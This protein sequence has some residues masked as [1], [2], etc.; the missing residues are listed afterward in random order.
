MR[1]AK[2]AKGNTDYVNSSCPEA[3]SEPL[4][5]QITRLHGRVELRYLQA[6]SLFRMTWGLLV[7]MLCK[8]FV[9]LLCRISVLPFVILC[10]LGRYRLATVIQQLGHLS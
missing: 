3:A 8:E 2:L 6:T 1:L 5:S 4:R 10:K 9:V 7:G